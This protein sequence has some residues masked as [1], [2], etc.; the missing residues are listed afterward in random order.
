MKSTTDP[1]HRLPPW[2]RALDGARRSHGIT[3]AELCRRAAVS[4]AAWYAALTGRRPPPRPDALRR[5]ADQLPGLDADA[6][7][8]LAHPAPPPR[9]S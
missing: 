2:A 8:A 9:R 6:L 4:R 3:V 7:V 1:P 5:L